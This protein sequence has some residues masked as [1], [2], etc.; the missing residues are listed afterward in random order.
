M[1][2]TYV[3]INLDNIA[4]NCK[5]VINKYND[6][7]YYIAVVKGSA[8]GHGEYIVNTL[9]ENGINYIAVSSLEEGLCVRKYNK[10]VPVLLL[11]PIDISALDIALDNNF[12][13]TV[14]NLD[15]IK[16]LT[17]VLKSK[18]KCH[19]KVDSGMGRLGICSK[20]EFK[21]CFD[22]LTDNK[23]A[24]VEGVYSHFATIGVFDKKWDNQ[25]EKFKEITSLVDLDS[26]P[27]RHLGSSIVMLAHPKIDFCNAIR[28]ATLLYGYNIGPTESSVGLKNK[29]RVF[30]NRYYKKKFNISETYSNVEIDLKPCM[31]FYTKLLQI[32]KIPSGESIGYGAKVHLKRDTFVGVIDL[33]Y[34]NGIGTKNINRYVYINN[35]K[36]KVLS[37][38]MNM[39]FIEV[40]ESVSL[41]DKVV[42]LDG[43][44]ITIGALARFTDR[45]FHE[46]LLSVGKSNK[47]VY[48]KNGEIDFIE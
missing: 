42:V 3:E 25:L 48:T 39:S 22:I 9:V 2:G 5:S 17:K 21:E 43:D 35:K 38:G 10:K 28:T 23:F 4:N 11:E 13:L 44:N 29:L 19:I 7:D 37:V 36:Y 18:I 45:T 12:T 14:H 20:D 6:Y 32:K 47:R 27:I 33:G 34:N 26:I 40:D 24:Y 15:Y 41:D 16:S 1:N 31:S 30:R 8:Y 46:M